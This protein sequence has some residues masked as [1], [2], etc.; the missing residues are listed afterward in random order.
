M[1]MLSA[2]SLTHFLSGEDVLAVISAK[3][4][5]CVRARAGTSAGLW[6]MM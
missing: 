3:S 5:A 6:F 4:T 2:I 1:E